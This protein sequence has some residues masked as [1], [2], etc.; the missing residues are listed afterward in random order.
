MRTYIPIKIAD[1]TYCS[2]PSWR[3]G[4]RVISGTP[5]SLEEKLAADRKFIRAVLPLWSGGLH[6]PVEIR[7][8][9]RAE[10]N[11]FM[12]RAA[13]V[14]F[15]CRYQSALLSR[16]CLVPR[17]ENPDSSLWHPIRVAAIRASPL[18]CRSSPGDR[19]GAIVFQERRLKSSRVRPSQCTARERAAPRW[20]PC[21]GP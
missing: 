13:R 21:A 15:L 11:E 3:L 12:K 10:H 18:C 5:S 9:S 4:R 20:N 2:A 19:H 14:F 6:L 7:Q 16:V 8:R 17:Q 1:V